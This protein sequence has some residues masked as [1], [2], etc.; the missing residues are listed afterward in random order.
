MNILLTSAGRRSYLVK[1]FK[2]VLGDTGTVHAANSS[3]YSSAMEAADKAVCTPIIYSDKYISFL[4]E[5]CKNEKINVII[6]LFDIDIP[7]L[8]RSRERFD[9][10]GVRLIVSDMEIVEICNDK[11]LTYQFLEKNGFYVPQTFYDLQAVLDALQN[12]LVC[13]PMV[14]K[15]RWGMG[16]IDMYEA[17]NEEELNVLFKKAKRGIFDSYLKYESEADVEKCV[18]IQQKINGQE[19]GIDIIN[20]LNGSYRSTV[21]R[22]KI[23][24]RSGETDCAKIVENPAIRETAER[25]AVLTK[26]IG[27]MDVDMFVSD[28][29]VYVLEM[30]A[31]FGGGYPF[32][33][34]AGVD[35]PR[36]IIQWLN[37][38]D[39]DRNLLEAKI[40]VIG[41]KDISMVKI[42]GG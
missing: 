3:I 1:Y 35:L 17:E 14:I 22:K 10:I 39:V 21:I 25:L 41:Q 23:S 7:V 9:E 29:K 6:P 8:A 33:H 27:N 11:W 36:A 30:N 28:D 5:Y 4:L 26:H 12:K 42:L 37:G 31:R 38:N 16:S 15:P 13:F 19:Y 18:I 2:D 40:G 24:M 32:S 20:D 34:I